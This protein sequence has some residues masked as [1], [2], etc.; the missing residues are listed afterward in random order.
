LIFKGTFS[1]TTWATSLSVI[2]LLITAIFIL[3]IL[4]RV[5]N[6]PLNE[7]WARLPDLTLT[8][9]VVVLPSIALMFLL[10]IYPQLV[11]GVIGS[12]AVQMVNRLHL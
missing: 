6:G 10:G 1:L 5:F 9:R 3:T 8:E 11:L 4:Q 7:K 2:G 12:T